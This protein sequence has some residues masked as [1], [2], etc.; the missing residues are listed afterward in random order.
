VLRSRSRCSWM[1]IVSDGGNEP[2]PGEIT[3]KP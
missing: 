1:G 2:V 3:Y